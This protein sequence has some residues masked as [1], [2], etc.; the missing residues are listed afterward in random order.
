MLRVLHIVG[1]MDR[2]GAETMIMNLFRHI[3]RQ[4]VQFDFIY[5]K[6]KK[7]D[8]DE[9]IVA[10][11]GNIYRILASNPVLRMN[12]L[13]SFLK[14]HREYNIVHSHTLLNTAFNLIAAKRAGVK[15]RIAHSHNTSNGSAGIIGKSYEKLAIKAINSLATSF[16]SCGKEA[17]QFLFPY[18]R[19]VI[20]LPNAVDV[21]KLR[22]IKEDC[23]NYIEEYFDERSAL[24][25]L[26]VGRLETAKNHQFTIELAEYMK[27]KQLDVKFFLAG[28]GP[29][30]HE[31]EQQIKSKHLEKMVFLLGV[32]DDVLQL[33]A[34]AD[35]M[36][37]PSL[38]EG[39]PVVLAEA[40]AIGLSCVI[41]NSIASEV[42]LDLGLIQFLS[43]KDHKEKWTEKIM[44]GTDKNINSDE[45]VNKLIAKGFDAAANAQ[46]LTEFYKKL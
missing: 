27:S 33:M 42:D 24:K 10:L 16:F 26:Q 30:C 4:E 46:W 23:Q 7:C 38:F 17:S 13:T 21:K 29:L 28:Q 8:Y 44:K 43:L 11:G 19:D 39:F 41:S 34:G 31:I 3:N 36:I 45:I 37:M 25:V 6:D 18:N 12:K 14:L 2:A 9:E 5:F 20:V 40:Q 32:R 15:H 22:E 1:G 35:I